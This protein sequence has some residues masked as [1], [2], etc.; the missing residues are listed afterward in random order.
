MAMFPVFWGFT[1]NGTGR[2]Y[3]I[4]GMQHTGGFCGDIYSVGVEGV[5]AHG[6]GIMGMHFD[7]CV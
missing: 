7:F 2:T 3:G 5:G 1:Y 4:N 6:T